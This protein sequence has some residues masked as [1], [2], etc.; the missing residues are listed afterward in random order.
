MNLCDFVDV[1]G[2]F[3][4]QILLFV[5]IFLALVKRE[6]FEGMVAIAMLFLAIVEKIDGNWVMIGIDEEIEEM[7]NVTLANVVNDWSLYTGRNF[8][9]N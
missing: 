1:K 2:G 9:V 6:E 5:L 3:D 4:S 7:K 8:G